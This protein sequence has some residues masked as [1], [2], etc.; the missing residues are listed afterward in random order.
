MA[1][2]FKV[3]VQDFGW[4]LM[5]LLESWDRRAGDIAWVAYDVRFARFQR[6]NLLY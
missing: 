1:V 2:I 3:S 6:E 4:Q 5:I